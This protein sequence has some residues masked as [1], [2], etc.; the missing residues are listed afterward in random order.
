[1]S[2]MFAKKAVASSLMADVPLGS[3]RWVERAYLNSLF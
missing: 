3:G 2:R 1:M